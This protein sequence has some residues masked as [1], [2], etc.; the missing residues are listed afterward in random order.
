MVDLC[1]AYVVV[2]GWCIRTIL[3][4][5]VVHGEQL[6]ITVQAVEEQVL[7]IA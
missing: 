6:V 7:S 2:T 5:S 1:A 4:L 3:T